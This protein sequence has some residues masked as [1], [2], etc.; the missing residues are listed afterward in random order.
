MT[1]IITNVA[2]MTA[3]QTLQSTNN[4][5]E[6]T[7][8]RISTGYRVS[9]AKDN[10]A[11]WSIATSMR[12]DNKAMSA[13]VDSLGIGA[14]IVDTGY[15][16]LSS[17]KDVLSEIKAKLTT[18]TSD[19]VD[20]TKIQEEINALK[21]QLKTIS[22]SASF[23]G[24]NWLSNNEATSGKQI[25]SSLSRDANGVLTVGAIDV[26]IDGLRLYSTVGGVDG[27]IL[28]KDID[29]D[30]Y[31]T[32]AM[33][34]ASVETTAVAFA[35]TDDK[36]SFSISQNGA[37]AR[38]VEITDQT[39]ADAGLSDTSI[40]SDADL[41]AVFEQALSDAGIDGIDVEIDAA[42]HN[43]S[44]TSLESF[45]VSA[46]SS[47]GTSTIG[48]ASLGLDAT[49][50]YTATASGSYSTSIEDL[51]I[52]AATSDEIQAYIKVVDEA[53]SQV[54]TAASSLGAVQNRIDMQTEFVSKLMDTI[55]MGVGTL[56]D[57][58]MT[59]ESTRLK[60]LQTQQQLGVQA[61]SI[62]NNSSQAIMQLFQ[63]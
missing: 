6:E 9:E 56:V 2:A 33:G 28:N 53:L 55:D 14:A 23:S 31:T 21:D 24:Q 4:M 29:I 38:T 57:A 12:S 5:L 48:V 30:K 26:D 3:L 8:N 51:D 17:A 10:A 39:L 37:P 61:L 59:E 34:T 18:A 50:D 19:G 54:T 22:D 42:T 35:A 45:T 11:Y 47:S 7:Q 36:V 25:I 43:V 49:S 40:R 15:T 41:K 16:A 62:A 27:G 60:A 20:R 44:F 58:D 32:G 63:G 46:A 13:V 52:S 1:S